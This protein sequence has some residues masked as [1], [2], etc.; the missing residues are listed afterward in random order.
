MAEQ[1]LNLADV[2]TLFQQVDGKSVSQG[3]V[4]LLMIHTSQKSA[5]AIILAMTL[6]LRSCASCGGR[7]PLSSL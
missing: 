5:I 4:V 7:A 2:G 3:I 6:R 1:E